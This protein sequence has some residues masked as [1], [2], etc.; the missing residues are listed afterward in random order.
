MRW[1]HCL[2]L[3]CGL[4][5]CVCM[6]TAHRPDW[7]PRGAPPCKYGSDCY[8]KSSEHRARFA[9]PPGGLD[10]A[11]IVIADSSDED[12][13]GCVVVNEG[14]AGQ[15]S[16]RRR[17]DAGVDDASVALARKL[18]REED[19]AY[20]RQLQRA[21]DEASHKARQLQRKPDKHC[22][23]ASALIGNGGSA[24]PSHPTFKADGLGFWLLHTEGIEREAN[25]PGERKRRQA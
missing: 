6:A 5:V 18:Q 15:A 3:R 10:G 2:P 16:K 14:G 13:D 9:H 12:V 19:E 7:M 4:T 25:S 21:E 1:P 22:S 23:R 17:V 24:A 11:A 8:Q 20:T